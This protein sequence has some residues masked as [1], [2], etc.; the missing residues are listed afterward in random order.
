MSTIATP[1][2]PS[3]PLRRT[4]SSITPTSSSRPSLDNSAAGSP[5]PN[6]NPTFNSKDTSSS[7]STAP[8]SKR[9]SRAALREYYNLRNNPSTPPL[10]PTVEITDPPTSPNPETGAT[11]IL[12]PST[13]EL[14]TPTFDAPTYVSHLLRTS[15]LAE[16]LRTYTRV[17]GEMRALDAERKALVYDNYSKLIAATETIRRMRAAGSAGDAS[18]TSGGIGIG[19][20]GLG[21]GGTERG[22]QEVV[23]L[24]VQGGTLEGV[25]EGIYKRAAALRE[26]LRA[27]VERVEATKKEESEEEKQQRERVERTRELAREVLQVPE[28]LRRL[29]DEGKVEEAKTE[30]EAPRRLLVRW[31]ELG[32]GGDDVGGLIDEGDAI[33]RDGR[34]SGES[35]SGRSPS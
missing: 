6:S 16:L 23:D 21:V 24:L 33:L 15:S 18:S 10:P 3:G 9:A 20:V 27:E 17:L 7:S 25:V 8:Q 35:E 34:S 32:V 5:N 29:V 22:G 30:W 1:R 11:T 28:R 19:G 4:N 2:D 12:N 31:R 14:D 26:E 13:S